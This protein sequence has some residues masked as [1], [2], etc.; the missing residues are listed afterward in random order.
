M[1]FRKYLI[2]RQLRKLEKLDSEL[3]FNNNDISPHRVK[4][5]EKKITLIKKKIKKDKRKIK[6]NFIF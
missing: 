2:E 6:E 3:L 5:I 4:E 1:I